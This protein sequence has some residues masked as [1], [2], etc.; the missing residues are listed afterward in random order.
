MRPKPVTKE[1][2][3]DYGTLKQLSV[4]RWRVDGLDLSGTRRRKL[5]FAAD[6]QEALAKAESVLKMPGAEKVHPNLSIAETLKREAKTRTWT[7]ETA[8]NENNACLRFLEWVDSQKLAFWHE[9]KLEHVQVYKRSLIKRDMAY[10]SIRLYTNPIR[11]ASKWA[12]SNYPDFYHDF[13]SSFRLNRR[14]TAS[15]KVG[16]DETAGNP[17]LSIGE[18]MD[19]LAWLVNHSEWNRLTAG[20]ALQSVAGLSLMEAYRMTWAQVNFEKSSITIEGETKNEYR[21][22][23]IPVH[24]SV[25]WTLRHI[26]NQADK[27]F[28]RPVP[29]EDKDGYAKELRKAF[30]AYGLKLKPKEIGRAHV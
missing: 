14:E 9:M 5:F 19:L 3:T 23:R 1:V 12:A 24:A 29:Y 28:I 21:V 4:N 15:A 18:I 16:Y 30:K 27:R 10:D 20:V 13:C 17:G 7:P 11:R 6:L 2:K 8:R 22:R 26:R 25:A